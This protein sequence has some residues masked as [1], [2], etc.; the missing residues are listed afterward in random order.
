MEAKRS[1]EEG[2]VFT[3]ADASSLA[4]LQ[5]ISTADIYAKT[6]KPLLDTMSSISKALLSLKGGKNELQ[7][8]HEGLLSGSAAV[9]TFQ[10]GSIQ[11]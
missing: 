1:I 6:V 8:L 3:A 7:S 4:S 2:E 9:N 11:N 5:H 10:A